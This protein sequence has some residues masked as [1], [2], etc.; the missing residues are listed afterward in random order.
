MRA[1]V[2]PIILALHHLDESGRFVLL[3][4]KPEHHIPT[5]DAEADL[6]SL[7]IDPGFGVP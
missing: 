4:L 7:N 2:L 1:V 3:G 5:Y 6:F